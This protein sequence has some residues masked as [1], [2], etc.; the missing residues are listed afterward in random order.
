[1]DVSPSSLP[2]GRSQASMTPEFRRP[3][4]FQVYAADELAAR[5][6]YALSLVERGLLDAMR[7]VIWCDDSIP[8]DPA[9]IALAIR[10]SEGEVRAA[11]TD[12]VRSLFEL[13]DGD[14]SRLTCP[15]LRRQMTRLLE[16][17]RKQSEAADRTNAAKRVADR[18]ANR[19]GQRDCQGGA[20]EQNRKEQNRT[21]SIEK[22]LP[23]AIISPEEVAEYERA[24]GDSTVVN[25]TTASNYRRATG[26]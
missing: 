25:T 4:A 5:S 1:M 8:A 15:E 18:P 16:K 12:G 14:Q 17:R 23:P 9:G 19:S 3:P 24:F 10:R 13:V 11:L 22:D 2:V 20:P 26:R 21:S 7:R 6:Y